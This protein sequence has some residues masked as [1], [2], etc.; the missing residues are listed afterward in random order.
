MVDLGEELLGALGGEAQ[1]QGV[2]AGA[3]HEHLA[4]T[5]GEGGAGLLVEEALAHRDVQELAAERPFL[6][7]ADE[8]AVPPL[9]DE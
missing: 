7:P 8:V 4:G 5:V 2:E 3:D 1:R 9:A 6:H